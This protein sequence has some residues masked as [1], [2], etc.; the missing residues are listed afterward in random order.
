MFGDFLLNHILFR[1]LAIEEQEEN[2]HAPLS[3]P[4]ELLMI[5]PEMEKRGLSP[6]HLSILV[7]KAVLYFSGISS[8]MTERPNFVSA[9]GLGYLGW[10]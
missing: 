3:C 7:L 1:V 4:S 10:S 2:S 6:I 9:S 5:L 8:T